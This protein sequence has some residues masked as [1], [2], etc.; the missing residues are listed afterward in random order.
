MTHAERYGIKAL[1]KFV[2]NANE[3]GICYGGADI[4]ED[5]QTMVID[6]V[7]DYIDKYRQRGS[8]GKWQIKECSQNQ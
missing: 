5:V 2:D 1:E 3:M 7:N 8:E 4:E 6:I